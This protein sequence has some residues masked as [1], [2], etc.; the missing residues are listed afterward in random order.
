MDSSPQTPAKSQDERVQQMGL[1][2]AAAEGDVG[3]LQR[4][5]DTKMDPN[6]QDYDLR[7]ALHV[8][9]SH[10]QLKS[11]EVLLKH[12]ADPN[13]PDHMA[14]TP[15]Y[16]ARTS[17]HYAV[18]RALVKAGAR[19]SQAR[20]ADQAI[21]ENWAIRRED[22]KLGDLLSETIKSQ[23]FKAEWMGAHV[24]AK[25][26]RVHKTGEESDNGAS[27]SELLHEIEL[28]S[29]VRHPD[30]VMFL[31]ACLHESSVMFISELM[32]GGDL[33]R[34]FMRKRS[35]AGSIFIPGLHQQLRW[36]GAVARGLSFLHGCRN[37][38][39]HR[40]LKPLNLLM[41]RD[42]K[43]V[44]VTDF[45]IG[46]MTYACP[47]SVDRSKSISSAEDRYVMT[48]GVGS[49]RYMAPEVVRH[50]SYNEKADIFSFGLIL[51]F[52]S[53]GRDPFHE[54]KEPD[55]MLKEYLKGNEPR[56]RT[57]DCH[58]HLR[59]VM[60]AAWHVDPDQRPAAAEIGTRL[61]DVAIAS[62]G[63]VVM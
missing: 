21:R 9:A 24:V 26:A 1:C 14:I 42:H 60:A 48:G 39:I 53:S 27:E 29:A 6:L 59:D 56:P 12:G 15:Y 61:T 2:Y 5:L 54:M 62:C 22:V 28:L 50:Q 44:K 41:T 37:R 8:A 4:L 33:E 18:E 49:W 47:P 31:G 10:G 25:L 23:V 55:G 7:S 58:K 32:E 36:A 3:E 46:K 43:D 20:L 35:E 57:S 63:C 45:G 30:L 40:D 19:P 34:Y 13:V 38:I 16:E 52:M 17:G 11:V 51:Y